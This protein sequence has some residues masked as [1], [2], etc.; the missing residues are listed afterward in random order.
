VFSRDV[1]MIELEFTVL[2]ESK[3]TVE[4]HAWNTTVDLRKCV[5]KNIRMHQVDKM[6]PVCLHPGDPKCV[7]TAYNPVKMSKRLRWLDIFVSINR[8]R[9]QFT[10]GQ[11]R[12]PYETLAM[13]SER[14]VG[15]ELDNI[16]PELATLG[17]LFLYGFSFAIA[18]LVRAVPGYFGIAWYYQVFIP[19][20]VTLSCAALLRREFTHAL[21][22]VGYEDQLS[23]RA[24]YRRP[25]SVFDPATRTKERRRNAVQHLSN[26]LQ[27][28]AE[29]PRCMH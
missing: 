1:T 23:V 4:L 27:D 9:G 21:A 19:I 3:G 14:E 17:L 28:E 26:H 22:E 24:T 12:I 13:S 7:W 2:N 20:A 25:H 16:V 29:Q 6:P 5:N 11:L 8:G 15:S 18:L 10:E